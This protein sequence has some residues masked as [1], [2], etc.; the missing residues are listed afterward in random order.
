MEGK[1]AK[2]ANDGGKWGGAP[3]QKAEAGCRWKGGGYGMNIIVSPS[4][5][6]LQIIMASP[7]SAEEESAEMTEASDVRLAPIWTLSSPD[8]V[9]LLVAL[10]TA[11]PGLVRLPTSSIYPAFQALQRIHHHHSDHDTLL[12]FLPRPQRRA[13]DRPD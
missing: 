5:T 10:S 9:S 11:R 12:N 4:G 6:F 13:T 2:S 7:P 3:M 1:K 8:S